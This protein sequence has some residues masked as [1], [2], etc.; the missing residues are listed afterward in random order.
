MIKF[1]TFS[2]CQKCHSCSVITHSCTFLYRKSYNCT[3]IPHNCTIIAI[4][5]AFIPQSKVYIYLLLHHPRVRAH[6]REIFIFRDKEKRKPTK[7]KSLWVVIISVGSRN[8]SEAL[9]L[10]LLIHDRL[11]FVK[12]D[13]F[14]HDD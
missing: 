6:V 2:Q 14:E 8:S 4:N 11:A 1:N 10:L 3:F 13:N 12:I 5:S 9:S 7:K